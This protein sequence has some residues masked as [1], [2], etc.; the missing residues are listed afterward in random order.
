LVITMTASARFVPSSLMSES[1]PPPPQALR[2]AQAVNRLTS[3][4]DRWDRLA[5]F[6]VG[7]QV[8]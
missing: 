3:E 1:P 7:I 6:M 5:Y 4:L 2:T 8:C